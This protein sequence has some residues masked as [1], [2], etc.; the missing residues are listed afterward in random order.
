[1]PTVPKCWENFLKMAA[2]ISR[3][4]FLCFSFEF[5]DCCE[6]AILIVFAFLLIFNVS[7]FLIFKVRNCYMNIE[8][9]K[10]QEKVT[11]KWLYRS[12]S[13]VDPKDFLK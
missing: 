11:L 8:H 5:V 9:L 4:L 12:Q 7:W 6:C 13:P 2:I 3:L 10:R 1:M